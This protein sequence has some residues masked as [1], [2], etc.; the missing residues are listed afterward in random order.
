[1]NF[2]G[3]LERPHFYPGYINGFKQPSG[4]IKCHV[5]E[6][7]VQHFISLYTACECFFGE[8]GISFA[9][10][11][12]EE[13]F[14][15]LTGKLLVS[16]NDLCG[17]PNFS[18]YKLECLSDEN[19][20]FHLWVPALNEHIFHQI[21]S[22]V[23]Q[24]IMQHTVPEMVK[25]KRDL[26]AELKQLID[27]IRNEMISREL[28]IHFLSAA[29]Q[30]NIP[31][32]SISLKGIQY[33]YGSQARWLSGTM[34]DETSAMAM[35]L[36]SDKITTSSF[37]AR[38]GF[39]VAMQLIANN[40]AEAIAHANIIG[41]PV[42]IKPFNHERGEGVYPNLVD[43][44]QVI[45]AFRKVKSLTDYVVMEKHIHGRD[46][47]LIVLNAKLIWAIERIPAHITGDGVQSIDSLL[48][49]HHAK[50]YSSAVEHLRERG[51]NLQAI[52]P[53][54]EK[55]V[56]NRIPNVSAGGTPVAVFDQVHAD[57]KQLM[58]TVARMLRLNIAG[59]D[60]ITHDISQS[61]RDH[62]GAIIEVNAKPQLGLITA[63]HVYA[64]IL[65]K[66]VRNKGRI[67]IMVVCCAGDEDSFLQQLAESHPHKN[68]GMVKHKTA[69]LHDQPLNAASS[70]FQSAKALLLNE[71]VDGLIY[72]IQDW[73]DISEHGLPFDAYDQLFFIDMPTIDARLLGDLLRACVGEKVVNVEYRQMFA[74]DECVFVEKNA[75]VF[76]VNIQAAV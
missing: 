11:Q 8:H 69:Y 50:I 42:V 4:L 66:S 48:Q 34:T 20:I 22:F 38:A 23:M 57:N 76:G 43:E 51:M 32:C 21:M 6:F 40:E 72:C 58:E 60:F 36:V 7:D 19:K 18:S 62:G 70:A 61:W 12:T 3:L 73:N 35:E 5:V 25:I 65:L 68:I 29:N 27:T 59:I 63:A 15:A 1:M 54:N 52:L 41:Y 37:L 46:Y 9:T 56:V 71:E 26:H 17:I 30:H 10:I 55:L 14:I 44:N 24:F 53:L 75:L 13:D 45:N 67:P 39:P 64:E 49:Q 33:G 31:W 16:M 28:N 74:D 2:L 47:R